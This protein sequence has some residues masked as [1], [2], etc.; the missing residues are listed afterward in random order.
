MCVIYKGVVSLTDCLTSAESNWF[1]RDCI[2]RKETP[3]PQQQQ[4]PQT[5]TVAGVVTVHLQGRG[6]SSFLS[7]GPRPSIHHMAN[8]SFWFDEVMTTRAD[9]APP[10]FGLNIS[11][12]DSA[13]QETNNHR[14]YF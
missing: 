6:S 11:G 12:H 9:R 2:S 5:L 3:P 4:Q 13:T 1:V 10:P 14:K 7:S 8:V